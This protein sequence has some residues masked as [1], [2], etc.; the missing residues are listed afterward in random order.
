MTPWTRR[1]LIA[2]VVV[3]IG[4]LVLPGLRFWLSL[5]PIPVFL[6]QQPWRIFTYMFVHADLLH[7]G[8][9]MLILMFLGPPLESRLRGRRFVT[10]YLL[11]GVAGAALTFIFSPGAAVVGASGAV[12]GVVAAFAFFWPHHQIYI[13]GVFPVQ[14]WF[15]AV[16][17]VLYSIWSGFGGAQDGVAH[18]AHLGGALGGLAYLKLSE[19]RSGRG[20]K[21]F[22]A[23]YYKGV[24]QKRSQEAT[25][26]SRWK[27]IPREQLHEINRDEVDRL[28]AKAEE[29][30]VGS[31][32]L[33]ERAFLDRFAPTAG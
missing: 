26:I 1:I 6:I 10:L 11:S 19:L 13:M 20:S 2:N 14:A 24:P 3:F 21:S 16:A 29:G 30:G 33:D 7:I 23:Q 22:K 8:F 9:N 28:M 17:Y 18:F 12:L 25:A 15:L 27:L 4:T 32:T 5:I 31:L